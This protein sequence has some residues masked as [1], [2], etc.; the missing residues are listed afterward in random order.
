MNLRRAA[1]VVVLCALAAALVGCG[2]DAATT[3]TTDPS[4]CVVSGADPVTF[5]EG[6]IPASV[7]GDFPVPEGAA[8]GSTMV[9]RDNHRTEFALTLAQ[10]VS[11]VVQYYT[12]DLVS[13]GFVVTKSESDALGVW[14]IE[15]SRGE[16]LGSIVIQAGGTGATAL[17]VRF[18]SC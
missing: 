10:E 16:Q 11:T 17:V 7:P 12:V 14:H 13:A 1:A 18:N 15:F 8:V 5:G 6:T 9:D 3:L 4:G 2:D